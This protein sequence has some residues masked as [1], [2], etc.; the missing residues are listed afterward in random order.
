MDSQAAA[1]VDT[2]PMRLNTHT[3]QQ[4]DIPEQPTAEDTRQEDIP[5]PAVEHNQQEDIPEPAVE[6]NQKE[7]IPEPAME[8]N[9]Q[10]EQPTVEHNTVAE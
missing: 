5:E 6:H 3:L 1:V 2:G 8:H 9:Q 10:P 7:D 4:K